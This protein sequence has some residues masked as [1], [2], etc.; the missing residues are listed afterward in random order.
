MQIDRDADRNN[1]SFDENLQ[2][3]VTPVEVFEQWV[4]GIGSAMREHPAIMMWNKKRLTDYKKYLNRPRA[5]ITQQK[6]KILPGGVVCL[7]ENPACYKKK[8]LCTYKLVP[9]NVHNMS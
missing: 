4:I 5:G 2:Q 9:V 7:F 3:W 1:T 6:V 8:E